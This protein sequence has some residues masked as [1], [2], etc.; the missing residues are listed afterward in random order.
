MLDDHQVRRNGGP[1]RSP[2]RVSEPE[3]GV[4]E[5]IERSQERRFES[6]H[7]SERMRHLLTLALAVAG[8]TAAIPASVR[9]ERR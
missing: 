2:T 7:R 3:L 9:V 4:L 5:L 1:L 8:M 6:D